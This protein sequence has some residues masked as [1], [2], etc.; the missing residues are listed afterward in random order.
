MQC[1]SPFI[2][3]GGVLAFYGGQHIVMIIFPPAALQLP[4]VAFIVLET[5]L[6]AAKP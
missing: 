6:T 3:I 2:L 1:T 5:T 4:T